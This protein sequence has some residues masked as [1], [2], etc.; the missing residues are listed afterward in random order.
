[1]PL[2]S[3]QEIYKSG[4]VKEWGDWLGNDKYKVEFEACIHTTHE[5]AWIQYRW[6][7]VCNK[8]S[9]HVTTLFK[10]YDC[11]IWLCQPS[12]I[13][14]DWQHISAMAYSDTVMSVCTIY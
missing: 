9:Q 11:S 12:T 7:G 5:H 8:E 1:M 10:W 13:S 4:K 2:Y 3:N 6:R 14:I